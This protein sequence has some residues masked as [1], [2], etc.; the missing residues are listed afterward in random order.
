MIAMLQA[1]VMAGLLVLGT[2]IS[3]KVV[4]GAESVIPFEVKNLT[5]DA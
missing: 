4:V 1:L 3:S 5:V 2:L